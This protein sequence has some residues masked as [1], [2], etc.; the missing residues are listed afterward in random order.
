MKSDKQRPGRG[1]TP[2][3]DWHPRGGQGERIRDEKGAM[4]THYGQEVYSGSG[5]TPVHN[6]TKSPDIVSPPSRNR[7]PLQPTP[8]DQRG[9]RA[10]TGGNEG[11]R[12]PREREPNP[13]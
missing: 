7:W 6:D 13:S 9:V 8:N 4:R 5:R 10:D 11:G 3:S 2:D 12:F 1:T